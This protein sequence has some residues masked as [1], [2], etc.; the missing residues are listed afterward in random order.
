MREIVMLS[1]GFLPC[2]YIVWLIWAAGKALENTR[3]LGQWETWE[4]RAYARK[5]WNCYTTNW[6]ER[7]QLENAFVFRAIS[8]RNP[9]RAYNGKVLKI[10]GRI[11]YNEVPERHKYIQYTARRCYWKLGRQQHRDKED[12]FY[13]RLEADVRVFLRA[14]HQTATP[15]PPV[16]KPASSARHRR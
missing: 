8:L 12:R 4:I 11:P 2:V 1:L 10:L 16:G 7:R 14:H 15:R 3:K 5:P 9:W 13:T 6:V